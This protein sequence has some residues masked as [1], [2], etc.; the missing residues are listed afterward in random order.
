MKK[1]IIM[2]ILSILFIALGISTFKVS[3]WVIDNKTNNDIIKKIEDIV[4]IKEITSEDTTNE[5]NMYYDYMKVNLIDVDFKELKEINKQTKGWIQVTGTNIN[6]PYVQGKDN[7]YYLTRSFDKKYTDAGWVF[8]DYRNNAEDFDQNTLIYAH[9]RKNETMFGE[10]DILLKKAWF[11]DE[12]NHIIKI[13]TEYHNSIW[14]I[15]S[16]YHIPTTND[17]MDITFTDDEF[18]DFTAKLK[19]RSK[20]KFDVKLTKDD[21]ILTLS[22]CY[23]DK[24]KLAVHAKLIR[25]ENK[26]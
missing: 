20:H 15:F 16:V 19:K 23:N 14:Q 1:K 11:K 7:E 17:Y 13:S 2:V 10:L 6:Y 12:S 26:T 8:M 25:I 22:T 21:K 5:P 18:L 9:A 3:K 4:E 24:E